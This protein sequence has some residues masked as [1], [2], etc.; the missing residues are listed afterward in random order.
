MA[1]KNAAYKPNKRGREI[2][3]RAWEHVQSVPYRATSR[4]LFYRVLQDGFYPIKR[5][6]DKARAYSAF[7]GLTSRARHN[8]WEGWRPNTLADDTRQSIEHKTGYRDTGKWAGDLVKYAWAPVLD[9]W[10]RQETYAEV[11]YE[12][13]AMS[14]QF[15]HYTRGVTLRPFSGMPS[16][17]YKWAIAQQLERH[18]EKYGLPVTALYFGDFDDAGKMIPETSAA[19][20]AAWCDVDF[21][22]VR[23]GLNEG[24][25]QRLGIPENF[26]KPGTY[27]WEALPDDAAR[28][29]ITSAV[30]SYMDAS[31]IDVCQSEARAA[32]DKL[33]EYLRDFVL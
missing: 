28:D 31:V 4:W 22:F 25:G 13:V 26:D 11:W 32:G 29:M 19:D 9:H 5:D 1:Y 23:V 3:A 30:G 15:Q 8:G 17:A 18:A 16:I 27:Q 33:R 2:L 20:I 21:D 24:D 7:L 12:A 6:G 14:A 10:Y